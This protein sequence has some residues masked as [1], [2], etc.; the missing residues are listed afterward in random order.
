MGYNLN[1]MIV[2]TR[3]II[4]A[5]VILLIATGCSEEMRKEPALEMAKRFYAAIEEE[6][7][8]ETIALIGPEFFKDMSPDDFIEVL[9]EKKERYGTLRRYR[10]V[11]WEVWKEVKMGRTGVYYKL[12]YL[13]TYSKTTLMEHFLMFRPIATK[14]ILIYEYGWSTEHRIERGKV[15]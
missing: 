13:V 5:F 2:Y 6:N 3:R 10:I 9:K 1:A 7:Y 4:L 12:W 15:D 11:T 8:R 14:E